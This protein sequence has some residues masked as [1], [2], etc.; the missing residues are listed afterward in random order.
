MWRKDRKAGS[1]HTVRAAHGA[2]VLVHEATFLGDEHERARETGHSTALEAGEIARDAEVGL[3]ALTH[4]SARYFGSELARE[5][6]TVFA[7]AVC[8]RDLD[9]IE[10]PFPERGEPRLVRGGA[11][12]ESSVPRATEIVPSV[13][14]GTA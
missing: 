5:A 11:L 10:V 9:V 7:E 12:H 6:R 4:I 13:T 14:E 3:L 2:S 1:D 8:P